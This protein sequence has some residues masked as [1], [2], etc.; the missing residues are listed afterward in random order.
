MQPKATQNITK[1]VNS[2][3]FRTFLLEKG[4]WIIK[5]SCFSSGK[6]AVLPY[7]MSTGT[8]T[9]IFSPLANLIQSESV[10]PDYFQIFRC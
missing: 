9:L 8:N 3:C 6:S 4:N 1:K 2:Q 10:H 7:K 5:E